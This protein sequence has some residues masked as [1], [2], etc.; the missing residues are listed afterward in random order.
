M[1]DV[2]VKFSCGHKGR[3]TAAMF[4][5]GEKIPLPCRECKPSRIVALLWVGALAALGAAIYGWVT[6]DGLVVLG[7]SIGAVADAFLLLLF[8]K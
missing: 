2:T 5:E 1:P 3:V 8:R 6:W 7:A 4:D